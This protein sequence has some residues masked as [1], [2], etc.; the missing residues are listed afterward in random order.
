MIRL[1]ERKTYS[2]RKRERVRERKKKEFWI[3]AERKTERKKDL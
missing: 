2:V 3:L 1:T